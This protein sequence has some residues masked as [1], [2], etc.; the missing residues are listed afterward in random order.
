MG[1]W[2]A[3]T[4]IN[5]GKIIKDKRIEMKNKYGI[6]GAQTKLERSDYFNP[7]GNPKGLFSE[8]LSSVKKPVT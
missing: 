3:Q 4:D 2:W 6:D 1:C 7:K 8:K 5:I